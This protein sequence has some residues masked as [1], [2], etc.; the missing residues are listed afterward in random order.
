MDV[1]KCIVPLRHGGAL[2]SSR[3]ASPLVRLVERREVGGRSLTNPRMCSLKIGVESRQIVLSPAWR[4]KLRLTTGVNY[5]SLTIINLVSLD[6]TPSDSR[7]W[8]QQHVKIQDV[9]HKKILG[10]N[11]IAQNF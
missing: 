10:I 1:C 9:L 6:L 5:Y 4:S 3:A 11:C 7:H 2:N 8:Q